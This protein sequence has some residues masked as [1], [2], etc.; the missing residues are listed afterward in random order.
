MLTIKMLMGLI[1]LA[2]FS[3]VSAGRMP[4][5]SFACHVTTDSAIDGISFIQTHNIKMA[6]KHILKLKAHTLDKKKSPVTSIIEC[7]E[8]HKKEKFSD[9][10]I[11]YFYKNMPR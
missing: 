1:T 4:A 10:E 8:E 7:I 11:Q 6:K 9:L 3:S 5:H 2:V